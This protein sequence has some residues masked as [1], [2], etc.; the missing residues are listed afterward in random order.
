MMV[1]FKASHAFKTVEGDLKNLPHFPMDFSFKK[2][3]FSKSRRDHALLLKVK[4][5]AV[6]SKSVG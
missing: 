4:K 6:E 5:S 3:L 2:G 1:L